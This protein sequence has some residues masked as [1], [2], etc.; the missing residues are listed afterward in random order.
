MAA[1]VPALFEAVL[2]A[3]GPSRRRAARAA[4]DPAR[5]WEEWRP[6]LASALATEPGH[7]EPALE[8]LA[9][10]ADEASDGLMRGRLLTFEA[11]A[12]HRAGRIDSAV[13]LYERAERALTR[14]DAV[15]EALSAAVARV[16]ALAASGRVGAALTLATSLARR[17][18]IVPRGPGRRR[19]AAAIETNR[20]NALRLQGD[21]DEARRAFASA[22]RTFD[23]LGDARRGAVTRL[24]A[25]VAAVE[26]GDDGRGRELIA[27]A[28]RVLTGLGLDDLAIEARVN[29][30]WADVH[31][32]RLGDGIRALDRLARDRRGRDERGCG[33]EREAQAEQAGAGSGGRD[34]GAFLGSRGSE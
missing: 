5:P 18:S 17:V 25:G 6:V 3:E 8:A 28:E 7:A 26:A 24:N 9:L 1:L 10:A 27:A 4:L 21:A 23:A 11:H 33:R 31:A 32:G 14:V 2:R 30:A 19:T 29:L 15:G 13:T 12:A 34:H 22:A 20:G 16:D